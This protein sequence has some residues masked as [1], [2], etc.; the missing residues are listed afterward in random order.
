MAKRNADASMRN[1]ALT[2][3]TLVL[4]SPAMAR[5]NSD[6]STLK[7]IWKPDGVRLIAHKEIKVA[8]AASQVQLKRGV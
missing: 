5:R 1:S 2:S 3:P 4:K 7:K 8:L 6:A